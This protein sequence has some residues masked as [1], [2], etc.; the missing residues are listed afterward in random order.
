MNFISTQ[1]KFVSFIAAAGLLMVVTGC[2]VESNDAPDDAG[3]SGAGAS[4]TEPAQGGTQQQAAKATPR[5]EGQ[6]T[7]AGKAQ[8]SLTESLIDSYERNG[9]TATID[10]IGGNEQSAFADF[11]RGNVD[12]V[13]SARPISPGEYRKC[14][15]RGIQPVQFQ[16]AS[17]AAVL[18]IKNETDV[19]VDCLSFDEVR[20]M[21]RAG[22]PINSW[23]EVGY[24]H[25]VT[26]DSSAPRLKVAGPDEDSNVFGFFGQYVL[27]DTEPTLLSFRGDYQAYP[28]YAGVRRAVVGTNKDFRDSENFPIS[29]DV[30][31]NVISSIADAKRAVRDARAE[32]AK[33]IEDG[34]NA[35]DK[36]R[37]QR[38][39]D[40]AEANLKSLQ[41][42]VKPSKSSC[43]RW[44]SAPATTSASRNASSRHRQQ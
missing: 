20:N 30:L 44:R 42:D 26:V 7:I 25:D 8:G 6:I 41:A 23:S 29:Q 3:T 15:A 37:D 13:D 2:G 16:V 10:E 28:T 17:D 18:A 33:G 12:L 1:K 32:K 22:S 21:F 19:G 39:L 14:M 34:R 5:T 11:C 36:A 38:I 4:Y 24:D 9:G 31:E 43:G 27:G 35:A 40:K